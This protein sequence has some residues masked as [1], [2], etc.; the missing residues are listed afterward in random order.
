MHSS[1]PSRTHTPAP[2]PLSGE[3]RA[4]LQSVRALVGALRRSARSVE[5]RTGVTNAQLFVLRALARREGVSLAELAALAR[6]RRN[7]VSAVVSRLV[8]QGLVR[9]ARAE[10]DRRRVTLALTARARALLRRAP[11][12]PTARL[13]DALETLSEREAR[14]LA[15]G[16]GAL[17]RALA[18]DPAPAG[19]LFEEEARE[20]APARET[21]RA[22]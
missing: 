4:A 20:A 7:A 11:E 8:R 14:A 18:L 16:L 17:T 5:H 19:M 9:R 10:D 6:T 21:R 1:D 22:S 2:A 15:R 12:P 13:I 3:R